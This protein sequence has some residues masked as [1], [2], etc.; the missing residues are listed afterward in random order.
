MLPDK[1]IPINS[2]E[3]L[4]NLVNGCNPFTTINSRYKYIATY[5]DT[6]SN[7]IYLVFSD[8][9]KEDDYF[10]YFATTTGQLSMYLNSFNL[11]CLV[12]KLEV[13]VNTEDGLFANLDLYYA[14]YYQ[15]SN[16][17][18]YV[19]SLVTSKELVDDERFATTLSNR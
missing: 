16:P 6:Q 9:P 18:A 1:P 10:T 7:T 13:V 11:S 2:A 17:K 5:Y 15:T 12:P 3:A 4:L 14:G 8:L 19:L